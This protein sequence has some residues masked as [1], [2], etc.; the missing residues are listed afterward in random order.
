M[1]GTLVARLRYR[2]ALLSLEA[3]RLLEASLGYLVLYS[4]KKK[5]IKRVRIEEEEEGKIS[6]YR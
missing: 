6:I 4:L 5:K 3:K 1:I 2:D